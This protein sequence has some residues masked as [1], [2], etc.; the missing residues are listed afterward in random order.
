VVTSTADEYAAE[1]VAL[2]KADNDRIS[3]K[4]KVERL[5]AS[6]PDGLPGLQVFTTC[7][8]LMRQLSELASDPNNPEDVAPGQEDHA[9]DTLKYGLTNVRPPAPPAKRERVDTRLPREVEAL[10]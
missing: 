3:G 10:L 1:R 8:N 5:L 4:R 9:Y 6:L 2:T 7:P